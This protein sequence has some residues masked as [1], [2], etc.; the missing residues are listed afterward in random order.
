M[1]TDQLIHLMQYL[2]IISMCAERITEFFKSVL[3][4]EYLTNH[5]RTLLRLYQGCAFIF[6]A[7]LSLLLPMVDTGPILTLQPS[8]M[9]LLI[10]LLASGGSGLWHDILGLL[11]G[12][13]K[14][15]T[16]Q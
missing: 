6:G 8:S 1:T 2:F 4:M 3:N 7:L 13:K 5:P 12:Y 10:G 14:S 9:S 15:G 11:T 16:T